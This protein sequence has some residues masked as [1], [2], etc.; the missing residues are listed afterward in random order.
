MWSDETGRHESSQE[1]IKLPSKEWQWINDWTIDYMNPNEVDSDGW[2]Y[3]FD[4]PF[5]YHPK[6]QF[7]DVVRRRRWYR[8][9]KLTTTGPWSDLSS[10]LLISASIHCPKFDKEVNEDVILNVWAVSS[11]GEALCRLGVSRLC[12]R[13]LSWQHVPCDQPLVNISVGGDEELTHVWAIARDGSAFLRHGISKTSPSGTVWFHTESPRPQCPLKQIT[14]G[15]RSVWAIDAKNR[16]WFRE[17]IVAT[18]P[19]GTHWRKVCEESVLQISAN[20]C[21]DLWALI[22]VQENENIVDRIAKRAEI[23]ENQR[24][25]TNWEFFTKEWNSLHFICAVDRSD[26]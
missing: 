10:I 11:E 17:E 14:V 1:S 2:Q 18:F 16:L 26:D 9:C 5:E 7:T 13:G 3:S 24:M 21:D 12:P 23:N 6:K 25:G 8:K 22:R 20:N 15:K 19:E 4:F